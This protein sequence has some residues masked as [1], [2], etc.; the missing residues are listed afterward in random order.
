MNPR[1]VHPWVLLIFLLVGGAPSALQQVG[2]LSGTVNDADFL[3]P[4]TGARV[5]VM[6]ADR[7]AVTTNQGSFVIG[8]L[9]PD[10]YTVVVTKDGYERAVRGNIVVT[11]G[12]VRELQV[13]MSGEFTE[14]E[15]FVVQDILNLAAGTEQALLQ[16]RF[17]SPQLVDS[18]SSELM[19]RAGASDAAAALSFVAGASVE[20]GRFAVIRG[21][22]DRYVSSQLNG[23]RLPSADENTRAVE[24]DQF[25]STV[26]ESIQVT[27]TFTP[28]QQ[29][30]ASGGAVDVRLRGVPRG[31]I[32]SFSSQI[33]YNS[34][35]TSNSSFLTYNGG[36]VD[37]WADDDGKRFQQLDNLGGNWDGAAGVERTEAPI[38]Y[39]WSMAFGDSYEVEKD[40]FIGGFATMFYERDSSFFDNGINDSYWVDTVGGPLIPQYGGSGTPTQGDYNTRLF[41]IE[42]A[43]QSVQLGGLL[44]LGFDSKEHSVS[45]SYLYSRTAQ[46]RA[47]LAED[48]RGKEFFFGPEFGF[49]P[50]D[51]NDPDHP[52]NQPDNID[53]APYL[54]LETLEYT[55]RD[56][57]SLQFAGRHEIVDDLFDIGPFDFGAPEFRWTLARSF[58]NLD[59]PDKRQFGSSWT[60][61]FTIPGVPPFIPP[62]DSPAQFTAFRPAV[63]FNLGNFQRI[64]KVIEEDSDQHQL[65]L[66][67]PFE[68]WDKLPG[69]LTLG[70][71]DDTVNRRF[72]QDT[73]T[74]AGDT[75][76][77]FIGEFDEFWS[78]QFPF[79]DHPI[80]DPLTDVDYD[81]EQQISALYAQLDLPL[82]AGTNLIGGVRLEST[83]IGI[84]N[85][86]EEAA[87]W[88]PED[89]DPDTPGNQPATAPVTLNPGDADVVFSQDDLLPSI[90]I[91]Q[92]LRDD[93]TLRVAYSE[94]VARQTFKE[95]T[96]IL[97]QE[98]LGG[99]V[100]VGRRDLGMS[101]IENFDIRLDYVPY[102][103]ALLS[104]SFFNKDITDPIEYVQRVISFTFTEPV[105]YPSGRLSGFEF[106]ARQRLG[107]FSPRLEGFSVGGN[108]TFIDSRV[109]LPQDEI[110]F[111]ANLGIDLTERPMTGA[112]EHL[113]NLYLTYDYEPTGTQ[114]SL[115]YTVKG[116]TLVAGAGVSENNFVPSV[117][118]TEF[119]TLNFSLSQRLSDHVR[120]RFQAKNLTNPLIQEVYRDASLDGDQL[121]TSYSQGIDYSLGLSFSL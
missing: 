48:T 43:S 95:L 109:Q 38:D 24:L 80:L 45:M 86:P 99:P 60:P 79:E 9:P 114:V 27:K 31:P 87:V 61:A 102:E 88:F 33:G 26:I 103:G 121:N 92:E 115:F 91:I 59:Q 16:L 13:E 15:E 69:S 67:L 6:E 65:A 11:A 104:G 18:I 96:P 70:L 25:P 5:R 97:Q 62:I 90:G 73:F 37:F 32:L 56:T 111:F 108:A 3:A 46:D 77:T 63:N 100:F 53:S 51:V 117:F 2:S 58:A 116:D 47:V 98:F 50:Y 39:K 74:N 106:E 7:E 89:I 78:E 34:Q 22:P 12:Q 107:E 101:A 64:F 44:G 105:N 68:Q 10:T 81:G 20:G 72:D 112:P 110:D 66:D 17:E 57:G 30:D 19:S 94:T 76:S 55:E 84:V 23:V 49:D 36:G 42:S 54:R 119:D 28:D 4:I 118:A 35:A 14:M 93:L 71:F 29:G 75:N 8:Q 120:L 83:D 82:R 52:G 113:Y 21:L 40:A 41:D 1:R 85:T